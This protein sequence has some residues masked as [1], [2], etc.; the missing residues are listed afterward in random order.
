MF[1]SLP[2]SHLVEGT[3]A[4]ISQIDCLVLEWTGAFQD[5]QM[6]ECSQPLMKKSRYDVKCKSVDAI[7]MTF[8][9]DT[10]N[11]MDVSMVEMFCVQEPEMQDVSNEFVLEVSMAATD[12]QKISQSDSVGIL[13]SGQSDSDISNSSERQHH[14]LEVSFTKVYTDKQSILNSS[15]LGSV[16]FDADPTNS[17]PDLIVTSN[18]LVESARC[19]P[20]LGCSNISEEHSEQQSEVQSACNQSQEDE[21]LQ[22]HLFNNTHSLADKMFQTLPYDSGSSNSSIQP[23]FSETS[24]YGSVNSAGSSFDNFPLQRRSSDFLDMAETLLAAVDNIQEE[25]KSMWAE[26]NCDKNDAG[27]TVGSLK[28]L[29]RKAS[30]HFNEAQKKSNNRKVSKAKS[31][32]QWKIYTQKVLHPLSVKSSERSN[33]NDT[34]DSFYR[35]CA[36]DD[37][38]SCSG[39]ESDSIDADSHEDTSHLIIKKVNV[40]KWC[41][42]HFGTRGVV[43][44]TI[45]PQSRNF[46]VLI[47][48]SVIMIKNS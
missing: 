16:N 17:S 45:P 33:D 44:G 19:T 14:D 24:G 12:P 1:V 22:F 37:E 7:A 4:Q 10:L 41:T 35:I 15:Q 46:V 47:C 36:N 38:N 20:S 13:C 43:V 8:G 30:N 11:G 2:D 28:C 27:D 32:K 3:C 34:F 6:F 39:S 26:G 42:W 25:M 40:R 21:N 9:T 5:D 18:V 29:R 23:L 48:S 31:F